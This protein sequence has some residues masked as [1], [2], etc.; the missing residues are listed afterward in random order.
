ML[1]SRISINIEKK[2]GVDV[3]LKNVDFNGLITNILTN[4]PK[5]VQ[6]DQRGR[7]ESGAK[8]GEIK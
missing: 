7:C 1:I 6:Q 8:K 2:K 3:R 5:T 4:L